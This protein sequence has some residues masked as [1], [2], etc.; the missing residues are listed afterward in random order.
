M[1]LPPSNIQRTSRR[2]E[3]TLAAKGKKATVWD[4]RRLVSIRKKLA[5]KEEDISREIS[6][7]ERYLKAAQTHMKCVQLCILEHKLLKEEGTTVLESLATKQRAKGESTAKAMARFKAEA[8]AQG[9]VTKDFHAVQQ[10]AGSTDPSAWPF[11]NPT[12]ESTVDTSKP[13]GGTPKKRR[14]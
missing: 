9:V 3:A 7:A 4:D 12:P 5:D 1:P 8:A 11:L 10:A 2:V 14:V 6:D 13:M